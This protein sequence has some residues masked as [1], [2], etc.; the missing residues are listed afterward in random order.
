MPPGVI[1]PS[2][3]RNALIFFSAPLV[4]SPTR[5]SPSALFGG[6]QE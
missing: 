3:A 1:A 6:D 5:Y 2:F 4:H